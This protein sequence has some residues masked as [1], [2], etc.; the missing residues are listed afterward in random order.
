MLFNTP[1]DLL[2]KNPVKSTIGAHVEELYSTAFNNPRES[3]C[4]IRFFFQVSNK[5]FL[6]Q[7]Q[8]ETPVE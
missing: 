7:T 3:F 6:N 8:I 4:A 2:C 1:N 5:Y